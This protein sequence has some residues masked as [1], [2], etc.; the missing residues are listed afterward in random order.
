MGNIMRNP[1]VAKEI[2]LTV[3]MESYK[4]VLKNLIMDLNAPS[5]G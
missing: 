1:L 2:D 4:G 3:A 5:L